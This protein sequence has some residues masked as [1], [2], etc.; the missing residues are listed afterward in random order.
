RDLPRHPFG[1]GVALADVQP[2]ML[3]AAV[4]RADRDLAH[5]EVLRLHTQPPAPRRPAEG[6]GQVRVIRRMR[7]HAVFPFCH[8]STSAQTKNESATKSTKPTKDMKR[9]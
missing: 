3:A 9:S 7:G 2:D 6:E 8:R 5:D 1:V 4:R